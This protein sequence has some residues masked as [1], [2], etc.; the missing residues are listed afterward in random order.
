M[1]LHNYELYSQDTSEDGGAE[2]LTVANVGGVFVVLIS[3]AG[4]G[5]VVCILEMLLEIKNRAAELDVSSLEVLRDI[6]VLILNLFQTPFLQ[7]L[8]GEIKFIM[9]CSNDTKTVYHKKS[10]S[11]AASM[12][13]D[14]R[15]MSRSTCS[16]TRELTS[17]D[18]Y[19]FRPSLKNIEKLDLMPDKE[20]AEIADKV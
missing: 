3:G 6:T 12:E 1:K 11:R 15:S 17:A 5:I 10:G 18:A 8:I 16:P 13:H 20:I 9:Q 7:E 19:G 4:V 14:S 2:E